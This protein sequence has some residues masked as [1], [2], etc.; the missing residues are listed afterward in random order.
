MFNGQGTLTNTRSNGETEVICGSFVD[1]ILEGQGSYFNKGLGHMYEGA[2][3]NGLRHGFGVLYRISMSE[4][5]VPSLRQDTVEPQESPR[6]VVATCPDSG[7]PVLYTGMWEHGKPQGQGILS[8]EIQ[9]DESAN[10]KISARY[11]GELLDGLPHG[12]GECFFAN[13]A[14]FVGQ[15][16]RGL[17]NGFG[18]F[19]QPNGDSYEGKWIADK[20]CGK[21]KWTSM[22][23]DIIEG[24]WDENLPNGSGVHREVDGGLYEGTFARGRYH[25]SGTF[26]A[27]DGS[28]YVGEWRQGLRHG[29]GEWTGPAR[30][31]G[32]IAYRGDWADGLRCGRGTARYVSGEAFTGVFID[33]RPKK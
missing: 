16:R 9:D 20:R 15:W 29:R 12:T 2:F 11:E 31:D 27:A 33:D 3:Q 23:G 8:F 6:A 26:T 19:K 5:S 1:G 14:Y 32:E 30:T 28:V 10:V 18:T 4:N 25:G 22:R 13:G 21:G 17:R 24:T 7:R